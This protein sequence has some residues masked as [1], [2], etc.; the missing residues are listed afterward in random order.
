MERCPQCGTTYW[1]S[2]S[3]SLYDAKGL[4]E[5]EEQ[6]CFSI[7]IFHLLIALG[8]TVLFVLFGFV[9]NLLVHFEANQVKIAWLVASLLLG[10]TLSIVI[11]KL[12]R[13]KSGKTMG[14]EMDSSD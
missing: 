13:K 4:Q 6:G 12:K 5:E 9:I 3:D 14:D 7:L 1:D 2:E 10:G 11:R 8:L